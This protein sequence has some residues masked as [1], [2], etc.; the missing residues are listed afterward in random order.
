MS[1]ARSEILGR[2]RAAN[3]AAGAK[4]SEIP[5]A[6]N[7]ESEH[8][9]GSSAVLERMRVRLRDYGAVVL[10]ATPAT[11]ARV[12]AV[13]LDDV[14]APVVVARGVPADWFPD[15]VFDEDLSAEELD[16]CGAVLTGCAEACAETGTI[17]LDGVAGQGRRA[18]SLMPDRHVCVVRADQVVMT[19]PELLT[20]LD[21]SRPLTLISGPSATSDI[22]LQRV[23]GVHGPRTLIVVLVADSGGEDFD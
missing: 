4:V 12:I 13:G 14:A 8:S 23:E 6:Y 16:R 10:D 19:V 21:P 2:V 15:A 1:A 20:R 3:V 5:R 7:R 18:I 17:A 11:V 22:E 9:P